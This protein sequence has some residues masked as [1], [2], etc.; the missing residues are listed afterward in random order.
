MAH[1]II[2]AFGEDK[3]GIVAKVTKILYENGFNIEDSSMTRLN[4]EFTIMLIVK[5]ENGESLKTNFE[6]LEREENLTVSLKEIPE[7]TYSKKLFKY[8]DILNIVVYG[9][10]KPGIVYNVSQTLADLN[11][12]I[13][14]LR[15]EKSSNLYIMFIEAELPEDISLEELKSRIDNL[16][17]S[18]KVDISV[19]PVEEAEL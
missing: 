6:K 12:N 18:L 17:D 10:D 11:I 13:S 8:G 3:P 2:T 1:Y 5:G 7:E 15:T 9:A 19:N 4:N 16:K 14:D